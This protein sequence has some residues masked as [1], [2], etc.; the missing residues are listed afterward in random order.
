MD[1]R[2]THI[3]DGLKRGLTGENDLRESVMSAVAVLEGLTRPPGTILPPNTLFQ[4]NPRTP[5]NFCVASSTMSGKTVLVKAIAKSMVDAGVITSI[6]VFSAD[7]VTAQN[8]M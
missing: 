2:L 6:W 7:V 1:P 3:L 4:R 5:F 8:L